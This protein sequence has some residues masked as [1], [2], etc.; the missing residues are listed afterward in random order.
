MTQFDRVRF[1]F[2]GSWSGERGNQ[3]RDK[4]HDQVAAGRH[5]KTASLQIVVLV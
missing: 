5:F 3:A 2:E 1:R 4:Q